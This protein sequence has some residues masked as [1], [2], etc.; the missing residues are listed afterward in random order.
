M[1]VAGLWAGMSLSDLKKPIA[2]WPELHLAD[3]W[4][5]TP[6]DHGKMVKVRSRLRLS[7]FHE[8]RHCDG[9]CGAGCSWL[10]FGPTGISSQ[11]PGADRFCHL[12]MV[13]IAD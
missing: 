7:L 3:A 10:P 2:D 12:G 9:D 5:E 8:K 4:Q 13:T 6:F 11:F 1:L